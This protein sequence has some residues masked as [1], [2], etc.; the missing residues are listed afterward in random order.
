MIGFFA[1][2]RHRRITLFSVFLLGFAANAPVEARPRVDT[3]LL[4]LM[5]DTLT[6]DVRV[7][8]LFSTR[9]SDAIASGMTTSIRYEFLLKPAGSAR[10]IRRLVNIRLDHDIWEG[11][12]QIIRNVNEPDTLVTDSLAE[13][14]L[15]CSNLTGFQFALLADAPVSYVLQIRTIVNPIS[16]EQEVRTRK[17]LNLLE[18]GSILELFF[19][20]EPKID[21]NWVEIAR[22]RKQDLP[23]EVP[24]SDT[25]PD[26]EEVIP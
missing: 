23:T 14:T 25:P 6:V 8:S 17:W 15:F 1:K 16:P 26:G 5:G 2:L 19:S 4:Y 20:L 21:D 13:A 12:Y 22:F 3:P 18:R 9:T 11:Q 10:A 24:P 7:D